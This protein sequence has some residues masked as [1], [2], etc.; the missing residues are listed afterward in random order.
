M[1]SEINHYVFPARLLLT[2]SESEF[3]FC[4]I[5]LATLKPQ[6]AGFAPPG[7]VQVWMGWGEGREG[8]FCW[9]SSVLP[10][11][12]CAV[13]GGAVSLALTTA[14]GRS[15]ESQSAPWGGIS[16]AQESQIALRVWIQNSSD[17]VEWC[18]WDW[19]LSQLWTPALDGEYCL[20]YTHN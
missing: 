20:H 14:L 7:A 17:F 18:G 11:H 15:S 10:I 19:T 6:A 13:Y 9:A 4:F 8:P 5:A 2:W 3:C 1:S 16:E 12:F